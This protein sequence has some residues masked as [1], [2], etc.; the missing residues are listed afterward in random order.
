MTYTIIILQFQ[1]SKR[2]G[3]Y[4][5]NGHEYL[6]Q[7]ILLSSRFGNYSGDNIQLHSTAT[8]ADCIPCPINLIELFSY[9]SKINSTMVS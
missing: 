7:P 5:N 3:K 1:A 2:G 6:L 9:F 4:G 8:T